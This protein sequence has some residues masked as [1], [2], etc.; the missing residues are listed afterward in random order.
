MSLTNKTRG[1]CLFIEWGIMNFPH[2][3]DWEGGR[4]GCRSANSLLN[5]S[6][7][8]CV[9]GGIVSILF[10]HKMRGLCSFIEREIT[11]FFDFSKGNW[12]R[13][14]CRSVISQSNLLIIFNMNTPVP[15]LTIGYNTRSLKFCLMIEKGELSQVW[16]GWELFFSLEWYIIDSDD[17]YQV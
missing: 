8:F 10:S 11:N 17:P 5:P 2:F 16:G 6:I 15:S 3:I 9:W 13:M 1:F 12:E 4:T 7:P 14:T